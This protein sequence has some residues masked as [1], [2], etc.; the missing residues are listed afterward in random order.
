MSVVVQVMEKPVA[1]ARIVL[2]TG[3]ARGIGR[4]IATS[5]ARQGGTWS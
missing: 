5:M 1:S 2:V 3:V 4:A